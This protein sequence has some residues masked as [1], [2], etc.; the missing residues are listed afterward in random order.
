VHR[1]VTTPFMS[2][3][4]LRAEV[5]TQWIQG[6]EM[7]SAAFRANFNVKRK[8]WRERE[9]KR[10]VNVLPILGA[11]FSE[12]IKHPEQSVLYVLGH[13]DSRVAEIGGRSGSSE[14]APVDWWRPEQLVNWMTRGAHPLPRRMLCVKIWSCYSATNGFLDEFSRQ[15]I[16]RGYRDTL[17]VGY[18][19]VTGAMYG[20]KVGKNPEHTKAAIADDEETVLGRAKDFRRIAPLPRPLPPLPPPPVAPAL[21]TARLAAPPPRRPPPVAPEEPFSERDYDELD[22]T[23][24]L[25]ALDREEL[26]NTFLGPRPGGLPRRKQ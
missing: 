23:Q 15:M 1:F 6:S 2:D 19:T 13:S 3:P 10:K 25:L 5:Q 24:A 12:S 21:A 4:G 7:S 16:R 11:K 20:K 9:M 18:T 26:P 17:C 14:D 8:D 22:L